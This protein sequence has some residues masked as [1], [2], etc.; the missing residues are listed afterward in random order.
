M[1][2]WK[3]GIHVEK[4]RNKEI[5]TKVIKSLNYSLEQ[6]EV[7]FKSSSNKQANSSSHDERFMGVS[8]TSHLRPNWMMRERFTGAR[9][10]RL[11]RNQTFG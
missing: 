7:G 2:R 11:I 3:S 8:I 10:L 6:R 9:L 4:I 1:E 5:T